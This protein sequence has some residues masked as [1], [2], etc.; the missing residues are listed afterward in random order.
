MRLDGY[1]S[2]SCCSQLLLSSTTASRILRL[3]LTQPV[4][5]ENN[6]S[7]ES[8]SKLGHEARLTGTKHITLYIILARGYHTIKSK[9]E[10]MERMPSLFCV[11]DLLNGWVR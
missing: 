1:V 10:R 5:R 9:V 2:T 3:L 8:L 11:D 4:R 6:D 7:G